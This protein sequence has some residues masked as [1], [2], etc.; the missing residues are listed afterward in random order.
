MVPLAIIGGVLL[1]G[2]LWVVLNYNRMARLRQHILESWSDIDVELKRRYELIPNLV[3]TVKGYARHEREVLEEV[4]S[5]RNRAVASDGSA[6]SQAVDESA[7][8]L[9][10]K[11]LF[12]VIEAYPT[13]K[14]DG[15]FLALQRELSITEDRIAAARR[16]YNGNVREMSQLCQTF[17]TNL[18]ASA[19]NFEGG[20]YF[21]L[22]RA[23][24]RVVPQID[25]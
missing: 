14:A 12:A 6:A 9:A 20:D 3:E 15:N 4:T 21:E 11:K 16:F 17:P 19:F 18:L 24:E 1:L 10:L 5:L 23:A 7:L 8:L 22:E 2:L 25:L 13:L